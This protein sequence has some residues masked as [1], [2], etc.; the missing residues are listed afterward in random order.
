M[1]ILRTSPSSPFGRQIQLAASILHFSDRIKIEEADTN[2]PEDTLR[3][4]NPLGKIPVLINDDG[5]ALYDS[6]VILEYLD[7]V[8]GGAKLVPQ[9][10]SKFAALTFHALSN[11]ITDAA[12]ANVYEQR[13]RL[14]EQQSE[15]RM[16]YQA[17]KIT[18]GLK[19]LES[20]SPA[21]KAVDDIHLGHISL[22]C[23]LGYLDLRFEGKWR[24][25]HPA[26]VAWLDSFSALVPAFEATRTTPKN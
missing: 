4:Q 2:N 11:G 22:A 14:P 15:E 7:F 21:L 26:L 19:A 12:V 9:D 23:A 3:L 8:A 18:R 10:T 25:N 1:M 17:D 20:T 6:R 24:A 16:A 5:M 13:F